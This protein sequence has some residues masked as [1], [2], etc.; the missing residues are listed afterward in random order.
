M[1]VAQGH[2]QEAVGGQL[3]SERPGRQARHV[4]GV[5]GGEGN[6]E[7]VRR[8]VGQPVHAVGPEIVI[9]ALLA[10]GDRPASRS[11]RTLDGVANGVL[12]ERIER[13]IGVIS[14]RRD[15][16]DQARRPRILPIGSVG[17]VM[18]PLLAR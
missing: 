6:P 11:L 13:R 5:S 18:S 10:V 7:T 1:R 8:G 2:V 17:M 3:V 15:G 12:V 4:A 14:R 16:L 9:L